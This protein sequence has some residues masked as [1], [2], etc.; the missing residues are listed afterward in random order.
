M[1]MQEAPAPA[2]AQVTGRALVTG[3]A[4]FIGTALVRAL[5][6]RGYSVTGLDR[7]PAHFTHGRLAHVLADI[8]DRDRLASVVPGH[9]L[10]FHLAGNTENRPGLA[11]ERDDY[12]ITV[13]GTVALTEALATA[14][15]AVTVL[16]ST[17]LVYGGAAGEADEVATPV[18][19]ETSFAAAKAAAEAFL[20]AFAA[21][22]GGNAVICRLANIVGPGIPRGVVAD[23]AQRLC[24]DPARLRVLGDGRQ[25]RSFVHTDDCVTALITAACAARGLAVLNVSNTDTVTVAQIARIVA[26]CGGRDT[27]IDFTGGTAWHGDATALH[28]SPRRLLDLGW[29]PA[30]DSA[31]AVR[32][33]AR[34]LLPVPD[35]ALRPSV[36]HQGPM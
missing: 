9:D 6:D 2:Q 1:V 31:A 33:A 12:D 15:P 30:H 25:R 29:R 13:G 35:L 24:A 16:T 21:R 20:C 26:D 7:R 11:G 18:R 34:S 27:A 3:A 14:P 5:L 32:S 28:P 23:L 22:S 36:T 4:G 17:Q 19:P 8:T 10:V